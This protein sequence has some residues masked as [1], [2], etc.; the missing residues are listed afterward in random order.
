MPNDGSP[1]VRRIQRTP[2]DADGLTPDAA[3]DKKDA[4]GKK[5]GK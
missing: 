2:E 4:K 5:K 1:D 3:E